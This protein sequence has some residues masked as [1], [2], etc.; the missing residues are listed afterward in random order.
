MELST[1]KQILEDAGN[2]CRTYGSSMYEYFPACLTTDPKLR[3]QGCGETICGGRF[4]TVL[5]KAT[6]VGRITRGA[7]L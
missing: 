7:D 5:L 6:A 4:Y 2:Y 3:T 1:D